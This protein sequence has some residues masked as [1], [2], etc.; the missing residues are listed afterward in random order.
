MSSTT[1]TTDSMHPVENC[2]NSRSRLCESGKLIE[3]LV[4][5]R[6]LKNIGVGAAGYIGGL[7]IREYGRESS[8]LPH[9]LSGSVGDPNVMVMFGQWLFENSIVI[10]GLVMR[11]N[12]LEASLS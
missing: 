5:L 10:V 12:V 2:I 11:F 3:S 1:L 7:Q 8:L 6:I 4:A 9:I